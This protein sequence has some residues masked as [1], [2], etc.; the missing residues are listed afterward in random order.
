MTL[1]S[2]VDPTIAPEG[3]HVAQ[4]FI[5][6][7]PYNLKNGKSWTEESTKDEFANRVFSVIDEYA[8]GFSKAIIGKDVLTPVD[9]EKIFGLTGGNIFHGS[10][11]MDQLYW[12]RPVPGWSNY[13]TPIP[14]LYLCGAGTHPGGGVMGASGRNAAH[15]IMRDFGLK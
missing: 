3:Q 7:T 1:P 10:M 13:K 14:K 11:G 9:L 15:K 4:L 12:M 6:Y 8:P 2:A 5:Q